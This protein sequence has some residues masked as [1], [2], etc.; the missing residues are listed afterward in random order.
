MALGQNSEMDLERV[1]YLV[2]ERGRTNLA[3]LPASLAALPVNQLAS[4]LRRQYPPGE[5]AALAE[6]LTL[7]VKAAGK[8]DNPSSWLLS[9]EGLEM[10]THHLVAARRANRLASLESPLAD[11]TCGLGGELRACSEAGI[12][13]LGCDRDPVTA[14]L[15]AANVQGGRVALADAAQSP[16]EP[17]KC[18]VLLDPSRRGTTGRRFD[19][20]AFSPSWT[21]SLAL[22]AAARAGVMKAPPGI[23]HRHLPPGAECE[24]IQVGRSMREATIWV[25]RGADAGVSRAVLLRPNGASTAELASTAPAAPGECLPIGS[26]IFDPESCVTRAGLVRHLG[27]ILGAAMLDPQVA[28]LT[29]ESPASHPMCTTFEVLDV[30]PFSLTRVKERL[31]ERAWRAEEVRR[32]AFPIEPDDF[33]R[34]LGKMDGT[35]VALLL[36]T[37]GTRRLV[38][39]ARA[40]KDNGDAQL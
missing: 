23:D 9:A 31:R 18:V 34:K 39:V 5:A 3:S 4:E 24:F 8:V 37:I 6:Q 22:L 26:F 25:G 32:R 7:R 40:W 21:E 11:L 17:A 13:W 19:P 2:S 15:A 20:N 1:R 29:S 12:P 30:I 28:Y 38:V 33:R 36:T 14:R 16:V 35:G 27:H 10:M